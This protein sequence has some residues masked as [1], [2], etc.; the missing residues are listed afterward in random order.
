MNANGKAQ[1]MRRCSSHDV[2]RKMYGLWA[3]PLPNATYCGLLVATCPPQRGESWQGPRALGAW[4]G[5]GYLGM[6]GIGDTRVIEPLTMPLR[7]AAPPLPTGSIEAEEVPEAVRPQ[8]VPLA[9]TRTPARGRRWRRRAGPHDAR[10]RPR[11]AR[12]Q[13]PPQQPTAQSQAS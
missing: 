9:R 1:M 11:R 4:L 8:P 12:W 3:S 2:P 13:A 7:D 6:L 10:R 5:G